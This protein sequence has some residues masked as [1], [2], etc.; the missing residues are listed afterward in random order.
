MGYR[1]RKAQKGSSG[2]LCRFLAVLTL[3]AVASKFAEA[4]P[5]WTI[6]FDIFDS[7]YRE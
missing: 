5:F 1:P 7:T 6:S 4:F 3:R 2:L